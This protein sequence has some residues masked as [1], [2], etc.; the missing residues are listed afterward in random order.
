MPKRFRNYQDKTSKYKNAGGDTNES[1]LKSN[2]KIE[3]TVFS[4]NIWK[5]NSISRAKLRLLDWSNQEIT[6]IDKVKQ[7]TGSQKEMHDVTI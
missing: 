5:A 2:C 7:V 4:H 6:S 3:M 1:D